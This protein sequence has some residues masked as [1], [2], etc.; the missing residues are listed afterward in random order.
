MNQDET[1][2]QN[3]FL[4]KHSKLFERLGS[5]KK[6]GTKKEVFQKSLE[7]AP[8]NKS[9]IMVSTIKTKID[10]DFRKMIGEKYGTHRG[11]VQK[12]I[13]ESFQLYIVRHK[14]MQS[15]ET[16][17]IEIF[18]KLIQGGKISKSDYNRLTES[19][20]KRIESEK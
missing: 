10:E 11:N 4:K 17:L 18:D 1:E 20:S 19:V 6:E 3:N 15:G 13:E 2:F 9:K 5:E 12:A 7:E 16:R 8:K 14:F